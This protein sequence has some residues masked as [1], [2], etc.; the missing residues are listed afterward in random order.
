MKITIS[1]D[2]FLRGLGAS[3]G[4]VPTRTT[5]PI[6]S[7]ILIEAGGDGIQLS[8]TDLD[9]SVSVRAKA[10]VKDAGAVTLPA[11]RLHELIRELPPSPIHLESMGE[12][13]SIEC[14]K[15]RFRFFGHPK[16]DFPTFPSLDFENALDVQPPV[17][18]RLVQHTA[19]AASTEDTRPILN[20][21]LWEVAKDETRMVATNGH[22]LASFTV[23][24]PAGALAPRNVIVP[25]KALQYAVKIFE[26]DEGLEVAFG[27]NQL[28]IRG[29]G[30]VLYTRL[31]EG[32]YPNYQQVIPKDND[33]TATIDRDG[34]T[35]ALRRMVVVASDQTHR[36]KLSLKEGELGFFVSTPDVGEANERMS[37]EYE[38]E[39]LE[40]GFNASYLLE[41][42]KYMDGEQVRM[43]F[44]SPER[45]ALVTP[46]D[47]APEEDYLAL[48]MPLRLQE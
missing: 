41:V 25:P 5:L 28:A 6:L 27:E 26:R 13:V 18:E 39:P 22:R 3:S 44:K 17:L 9:L 30:N 7:E 43:T 12:K 29:G 35:R 23:R 4:V 15:T 47:R 24:R 31:I 40:I 46:A 42:L 36:V 48:V 10:S 32:P 11:R 34:L 8:A 14:E 33:K 21:V 1:Q 37:I 16:A 2:E 19:Y 45:A 20:G 38:G